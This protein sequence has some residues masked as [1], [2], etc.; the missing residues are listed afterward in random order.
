[1]SARTILVADEDI[2][3]RIILRTV[4]ERIDFIVVE[5][6]N[7]DDAM[8]A[9]RV[10]DPHLIIL[11]YPMADRTGATLVQRLRT[12]PTTQRVPILNLTSRVTQKFLDDAHREGVAVSIPKPID[13]ARIVV[14][15]GELTGRKLAMAR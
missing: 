14:V 11:N 7:A 8:E 10:C 9:A 4:L 5:A 1:V 15:V 3:T 6:A 12:L 2:D 13:V